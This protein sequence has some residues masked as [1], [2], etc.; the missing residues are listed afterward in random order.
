MVQ[1]FWTEI[2]SV[3][4]E[5]PLNWQFLDLFYYTEHEQWELIAEE[6]VIKEAS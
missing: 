1:F 3:K 6:S 5:V 2:D 4:N